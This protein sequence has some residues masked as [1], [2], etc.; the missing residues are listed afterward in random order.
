MAVVPLALGCRGPA[1]QGLWDF[2]SLTGVDEAEFDNVVARMNLPVALVDDDVDVE[3]AESLCRDMLY[4]LPAR[5]VGVKVVG[6]GGRAFTL[7]HRSGRLTLSVS[8]NLAGGPSLRVSLFSEVP[9]MEQAV[10]LAIW[11]ASAE[12]VRLGPHGP[13]PVWAPGAATLEE[14]VLE[15]P[16]GGGRAAVRVE[17]P[18]RLWRVVEEAGRAGSPLEALRRALH[19]A[20]AGARSAWSRL[21]VPDAVELGE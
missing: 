16:W 20:R 11:A 17:L 14:L 18:T 5:L 9:G 12:A 21:S 19:A 3:V 7:E 2:L 13:L 1:L 4:T 10:S 8:L 15:S 6:G